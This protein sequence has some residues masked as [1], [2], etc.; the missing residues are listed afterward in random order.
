MGNWKRLYV[1]DSTRVRNRMKIDEISIE[2]NQFAS[3][4]ALVILARIFPCIMGIFIAVALI[5]STSFTM[6][7]AAIAGVSWAA[8]LGVAL[9][10][11]MKLRSEIP[12][13]DKRLLKSSSRLRIIVLLSFFRDVI[14]FWRRSH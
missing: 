8:L 13:G 12:R 6:V 10:I 5:A 9:G 14:Q 1:C 7:A 11:S 2:L 3:Y 4:R